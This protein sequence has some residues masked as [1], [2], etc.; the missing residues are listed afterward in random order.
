MQP[1]HRI[2]FF[3]FKPYTRK[4][5]TTIRPKVFSYTYVTF[6]FIFL[7][8]SLIVLSRIVAYLLVCRVVV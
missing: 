2:L 7:N 4:P 1:P 5:R 6:H 8:A 3:L